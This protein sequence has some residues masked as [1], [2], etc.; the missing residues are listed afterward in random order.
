MN[1]KNMICSAV[2]LLCC[3]AFASAQDSV[4]V[5]MALTGKP[6]QVTQIPLAFG[7]KKG[8]TDGLDKPLGE[9]EIPPFFPPSGLDGRLVFEDTITDRRFH[10][11]TDVRGFE[12]SRRFTKKY[13]LKLQ[14][15]SQ[16]RDP[17]PQDDYKDFYMRWQ[18]LPP[19][20]DSA[21]I[22]DDITGNLINI[23]LTDSNEALFTNEFIEDLIITVHFNLDRVS[24]V[25]ES[26]AVLKEKDIDLYPNPAVD[27]IFIAGSASGYS[28]RI[29]TMMGETVT[30]GSGT[31]TTR[32]DISGLA[33]GVYAIVINA[34][35]TTSIRRFVKQ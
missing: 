1:F 8:A 6:G 18:E 7:I 14:P 32:I 13:F 27:D 20:I 22:Q 29:I 31:E 23:S 9:K 11:Y 30:A 21:R 4:V 15:G 16:R 28:Y 35:D 3:S 34:D 19:Q 17:D 2:A 25:E 10:S 12:N 33:D 26:E 5:R 24:S